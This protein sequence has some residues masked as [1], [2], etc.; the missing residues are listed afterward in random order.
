M[1]HEYQVNTHFYF[2]KLTLSSINNY[3]TFMRY[4][5]II[6]FHVLRQIIT[7]KLSFTKSYLKGKDTS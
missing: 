1:K 7:G 6:L 5:K 3:H 2:K 4:C